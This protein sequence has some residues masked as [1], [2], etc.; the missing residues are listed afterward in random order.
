ME[1]KPNFRQEGQVAKRKLNDNGATEANRLDLHAPAQPRGTHS[2]SVI[3]LAF[4]PHETKGETKNCFRFE[5][6]T[7]DG[8][9]PKI[10]T[11]YVQ[12]WAL[13]GKQPAR[14]VVNIEVP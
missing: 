5:E 8:Q 11:L 13:G 2:G 7:S 6:Q 14:L 4:V 10:G 12:K 1:H 3:E 9:P